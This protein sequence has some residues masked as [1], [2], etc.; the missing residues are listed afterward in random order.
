[1]LTAT[2]GTAVILMTCQVGTNSTGDKTKLG[3]WNNN[4]NRRV[5]MRQRLQALTKPDVDNN[6]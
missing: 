4:E 6:L 2:A 5:E 1:M 3:L